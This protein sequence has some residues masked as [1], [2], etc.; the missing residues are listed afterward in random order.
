M[1]LTLYLE[2]IEALYKLT[3]AEAR[4][5]VRHPDATEWDYA[6]AKDFE[7]LA[8]V[9]LNRLAQGLHQPKPAA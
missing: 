3:K 1:D 2:D 8:D 6:A 9:L 4:R 5:V 7:N